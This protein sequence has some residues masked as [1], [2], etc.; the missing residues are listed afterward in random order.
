MLN[1]INVINNHL[2]PC[3]P[4]TLPPFPSLPGSKNGRRTQQHPFPPFPL[5]LSSSSKIPYFTLPPSLAAWSSVRDLQMVIFSWWSSVGD[6][7]VAAS[8]ESCGPALWLWGPAVP[9]AL[10]A[11]LGSAMVAL[12]NT[13]IISFSSTK[14]NTQWQPC[15]PSG[16]SN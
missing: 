15:K 12:I 1:K 3:L 8:L 11:L 7:L 9:G 2:S 6:L 14:T 10:P 16:P 5:S 13:Y 4:S